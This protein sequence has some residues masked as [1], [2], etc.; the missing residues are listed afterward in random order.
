MSNDG[1]PDSPDEDGGTGERAEEGGTRERAGVDDGSTD[2]FAVLDESDAAGAA[3]VDPFEE[4]QVASVD[5]DAVWAE[6]PGKVPDE[7]DAP[8]GVPPP[9]VD[10]GGGAVVP[11]RSY[12]ERCEH[13]ADPPEVS[14]C[15]PGTEIRELVDVDHF[16][17]VNCPVVARRLG[18]G[19]TE[20]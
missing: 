10:V 12:C 16:R 4:I 14:C 11:K 20:D 13:F 6:L 2:P 1:D 9:D 17:V 5:E 18:G 7:S 15:N 19:P 3:D 8:V